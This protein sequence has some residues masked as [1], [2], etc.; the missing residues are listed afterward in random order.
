M[1][2]H[3]LP[4]MTPTASN[5]MKTTEKRSMIYRWEEG[6]AMPPRWMAASFYSCARN[7]I[8][9]VA[10]PLNLIVTLAWWVQDRWAKSANA[11]SWI[12]TEVRRRVEHRVQTSNGRIAEKRK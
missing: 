5:N 7:R 12:E 2:H 6:R 4:P 3:H 1:T 10:F 8:L 9:Y 11:P